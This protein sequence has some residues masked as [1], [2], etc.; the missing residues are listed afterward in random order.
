METIKTIRER[1][2]AAQQELEKKY[3]HYP[4]N[5]IRYMNWSRDL[6]THVDNFE[7]FLDLGIAPEDAED[8]AAWGV[9]VMQ[10]ASRIKGAV[11][12]VTMRALLKDPQWLDYIKNVLTKTCSYRDTWPHP[13]D[14][15]LDIFGGEIDVPDEPDLVFVLC[16]IRKDLRSAWEEK[17]EAYWRLAIEATFKLLKGGKVR[18]VIDTAKFAHVVPGLLQRGDLVYEVVVYN[19]GNEGAF[20]VKY[21]EA[22]CLEVERGAVSVRFKSGKRGDRAIKLAFHR[23]AV[24]RALWNKRFP[25]QAVV[26]E[27]RL[28]YDD[29]DKDLGIQVHN[30]SAE[31]MEMANDSRYKPPSLVLAK[32]LEATPPVRTDDFEAWLN[33][34]RDFLPALD[35]EIAEKTRSL[36]EAEDR[37]KKL[38]A[39]HKLD[40]KTLEEELL[41]LKRRNAEER[42]GFIRVIEHHRARVASLTNKRELLRPLTD[43]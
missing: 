13:D 5:F 38:D 31:E 21:R 30:I 24:D 1:L 2:D 39:Q 16:I 26:E 43:K 4:A 32:P 27:S 36:H 34:G 6:T 37:L 40:V 18:G 10:A 9:S 35:T 11:R 14:P 33:M 8:L 17:H 19:E 12:L 28:E 20:K 22:H 7:G 42:T 25:D 15:P 23:L 41:E 3:P 29:R